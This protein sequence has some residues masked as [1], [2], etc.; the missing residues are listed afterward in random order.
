MAKEDEPKFKRLYRSRKG[1]MVAGVCAGFAEYFAIDPMM[2]RLA[3]VL[4]ALS[5]PGVIF[6]LIAWL[7]M[8]KSPE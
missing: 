5:G 3:F 8:P 6:Y 1:K 4:L 7:M 2:V